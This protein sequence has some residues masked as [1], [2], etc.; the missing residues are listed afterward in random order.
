[1]PRG[2]RQARLNGDC[3]KDWVDRS[4]SLGVLSPAV[5]F[6]VFLPAL[7]AQEIIPPEHAGGVVH[8][9]P[10]DLAILESDEARKDLP[11]NV[12][13]AKPVLGFDLRFHI[14]YDA[15]VPLAELSGNGGQLTVLFRVYPQGQKQ[16]AEYFVQ[17]FRV[18]PI[19]DDAQGAVALDGGV[20]VG[21]GDYHIDWLMRDRS[22]R[23]CSSSWDTE[24]KLGE[25]NRMPLFL[26][27]NQIAES[28]PEPFVNDPLVRGK[29]NVEGA[30]TLKLLVNFA[31][32][33]ANAATLQQS[34][35]GALVS[36][37]K[38]I[39]RDP[40][41]GR[42][43]LVAF[44]LPESRVLYRQTASSEGINFPALG[45]ALRTVKLATVNVQQLGQKHSETDF[46]EDLIEHEVSGANHP[47]AVVFAGPKAMLDAD[48][49]QNDLRRIGDIEC[50]VFYMN[51]NLNPQAVPWKD[52][53]SH[54][55]RVFKGTEYTISTPRDLWSA[56]SEMLNRVVH[57]KRERAAAAA[58]E[59]GSP[60]SAA[61]AAN[62]LL[63][64]SQKR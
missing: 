50:P 54:A 10:S 45:S 32:Q 64:V 20:D 39:E 57:L 62:D 16:Q 25:K 53:I 55:I 61:P 2:F 46:L 42:V 40:R 13:D 51:Y 44:D 22:E 6:V 5:L 34:D 30:L 11:C 7:H 52:T 41:V 15:T 35:T 27:P 49:P 38:E 14:G 26:A 63:P 19:Q 29:K 59:T 36:I 58:T 12:A 1:L 28:L 33:E 23:I 56:T 18:P 37:L 24:A 48:V 43:S 60:P 21:E 8:L 9:F 3:V 31:P 17:H 4:L 47:D